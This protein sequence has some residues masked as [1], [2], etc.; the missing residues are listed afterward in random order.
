M[1]P[2]HLRDRAVAAALVDFDADAVTDGKFDKDELTLEIAPAKIASVCGF[3]KYD[4]NFIRLFS[5]ASR[6][7]V[8]RV[9]RR[10][11]LILFSPTL[12]LF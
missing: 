3:L 5:S 7:G 2:E 10:G 12:I 9:A 1:L 8:G 6:A 11:G 4:Q